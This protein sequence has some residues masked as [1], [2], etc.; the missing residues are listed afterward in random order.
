MRSRPTHISFHVSPSIYGTLTIIPEPQHLMY[1]HAQVV[2]RHR[3]SHQTGQ[4]RGYVTLLHHAIV[5]EFTSLRLNWTSPIREL[6]DFSK[7]RRHEH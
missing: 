2:P 1:E 5:F 3:E 6:R 4:G 7:L